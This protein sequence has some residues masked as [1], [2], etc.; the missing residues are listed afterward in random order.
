MRGIRAAAGQ[1]GDNARTRMDWLT[2]YRKEW[3][4]PDALAGLTTAAVVIPKALAYATIAGLPVQVGLY[5]VLVPMAVYALVGTS[6]VLSVSTST[7]LAILVGAELAQVASGADAGA[8]IAASAAI[9]FLAGIILVA[10]AL[11]R[12]G[13]VA[14]FISEP[15]LIGFKAG[16]GLVIVVD[17]IPKLLGIHFHK[18]TFLSNV[19]SIVAGLPRTSGITLAVGAI[20]IVLLVGIEHFWPKLPAPLFAVGAGIAGTALLGLSARGVETVG[21]I[22]RGVPSL[23]MP[24]VSMFHT[25]WP[26]AA[27]I[28][29]MSF[30]ETIAAGRAFVA[31]G[32]PTPKPNRELLATGLGSVCG[33]FFGSMA[34]GGGTSQTAVN[35]LA[36]ARTQAASL[37]TAAMALVT[38]LFLA[39]VLGLMPEATLAAVVIVYSIGLISPQDFRGIL[40]IRRMEFVWAI[41]AFVG[42]VALGTLKGILAA[43]VISLAALAYHANNPEVSVLSR[44]RGTNVFRPRTAEHADDDSFPG[45][46]LLAVRGSVF[47]SNAGTVGQ[48]IRPLIDAE[49]PKV[50]V[51]DLSGVPDLEYTALKMLIEAEAR[52]REHGVRVWLAAL[53]PGVLEV[54]QRSSLGETLGR[55]GLHFNLESAVAHYLKR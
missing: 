39:P 18:G 21:D 35:R 6:R 4:R 42:V 1:P 34:S 19:G 26:A 50:V 29:L 30:T 9:S 2:S 22:P 10:A 37:V 33:A 13:F 55:D 46:L 51:L 8:L 31:S 12:L 5:T 27:G 15:V 41:A 48:K 53:N 52:E 28:A 36:G 11:L 38:M 43:I 3:L 49:K 54:V 44:K 23:H 40:R 7:T 47:F 20:M 32:E 14:S 16:V 17:Q 24:D 45:L 25:L